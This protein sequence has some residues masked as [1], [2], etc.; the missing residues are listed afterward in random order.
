MARDATDLGAKDPDAAPSSNK[1]ALMHISSDL[2]GSEDGYATE[3]NP[4]ADPTIAEHWRRVYEKSQYECRH[5]YDPTL[6]WSEEEERRLVRK[7]DWRVCLWAVRL[8]LAP[9]IVC[10]FEFG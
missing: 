7:L 1:S 10:W 2:S 5:V 6:V 4:F 8:V 3:K 9:H